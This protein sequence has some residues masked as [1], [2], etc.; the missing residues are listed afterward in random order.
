MLR[1]FYTAASGMITQQRKT[2]LLTNN[3][4][5]SNTPGFK[6]DQSTIRAF[7]EMLLQRLDKKSIPVENSIS[8]SR[9]QNIGSLNTGVYLQE[10]IPKFLQGD[11]QETGLKTDLAIIDLNGNKSS[12]FFTVQDQN[13]ETKYTRNGNFT[14]DPNGYLTTANGLYVLD[15]QQNRIQLNSD[16]FEVDNNGTITADGTRARLGIVYTNNPEDLLKEGDGLY[17]TENNRGLPNAANN[18]YR[19]QQGFLERS[20]VDISQTMTD[21]LSTYRSFEANQKVLQ[22][23]D[24]SMERAVNEIG[25]VNG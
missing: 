10:A 24:K 14:I 15:N 11:M 16:Q 1:G 20:N 6:S 23:Y 18:Q 7:P 13:G 3:M 22:A 21:M 9:F 25:R 5:N 8:Y 17:R 12:A 19:L 4:A 2:D